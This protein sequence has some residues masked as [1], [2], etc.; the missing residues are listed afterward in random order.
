MLIFKFFTTTVV[1]VCALVGVQN[2]VPKKTVA[3][4]LQYDV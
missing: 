2:T 1:L 4:V 3:L